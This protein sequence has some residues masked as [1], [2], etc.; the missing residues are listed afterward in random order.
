MAKEEKK[1]SLEMTESQKEKVVDILA[2]EE[3]KAPEPMVEVDLRFEHNRNGQPYGPGKV[4]VPEGVGSSLFAADY[5]AYVSRLREMES[6]NK[7]IEI[8]SR[9][10]TKIREVKA[11]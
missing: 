3:K 1:V 6:T 11:V 7:M 10:V 4:I 2:K 5:N 8:I 9:G